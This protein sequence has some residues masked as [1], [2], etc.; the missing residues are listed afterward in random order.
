MRNLKK[1]SYQ[2]EW[3][4]NLQSGGLEIQQTL[5]E[6]EFINRW[7]GGNRVTLTGLNLLLK[8]K[9]PEGTLQITDLGCGSGDMMRLVARWGK[10][11]GYDLQLT[12]VDANENIIAYARQKSEGFS[13]LHWWVCN[14]FADEFASQKFDVAMCTLF[15]HHFT[16]EQLIQLL[17]TLRKNARQGIVI[18]DL[19]RH[20]LAYYSIKWLT[21]V[22]S[23][24]PMVKNDAPISVARSF[25]RA[26]LTH[27]LHQAGWSRVDIRW[28]WA[29]RWQVVA[30]V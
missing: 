23:K 12:G 18:N 8:K 7:L 14:V 1:R 4:D 22:F 6:L 20:P 25:S 19:H 5:R 29:F 2:P 9:K 21:A 11:K 13:Q 27:L 24:S 26:E 10:K 28:K 16:N 30:W 3:M 17:G 15:T